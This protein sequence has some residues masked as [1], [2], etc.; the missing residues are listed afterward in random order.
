MIKNITKRQLEALNIIY[1]NIESSGF[2]PS[3]AELREALK[4]ASNQSVINFLR[5]LENCSEVAPNS[6]KRNT[7]NKGTINIRL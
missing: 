6:A 5:I 4:V 2:P 1:K 7:I 3:M